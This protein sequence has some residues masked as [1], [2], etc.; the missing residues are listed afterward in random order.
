MGEV[1]D[2]EAADEESEE[3][4]TRT[5]RGFQACGD[6]GSGK[7]ESPWE[8]AIGETGTSACEDRG[9]TTDDEVRSW[10]A[11][12][13]PVELSGPAPGPGS[14]L[15]EMVRDYLDLKRALYSPPFPPED[16]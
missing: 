5:G 2:K 9:F 1:A 13:W 4:S 14:R 6:G 11:D 8:I 7:G 10:M 12:L 3:P 16:L 15:F